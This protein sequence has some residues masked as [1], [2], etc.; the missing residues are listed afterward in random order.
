[1]KLI[2]LSCALLV[3]I[4][5]SACVTGT[6]EITLEVPATASGANRSGQIYIASIDDEREFQHKP[7]IP[8]TPSVSGNLE[9]KTPAELNTYV[10]R[11]RNGYGA[12]MGSVALKDG[13]TVQAETRKVLVA[14]LEARGYEVVESADNAQSVSVDIDKF[15]AW[16]VPGFIS[17]GFES[18]VELELE[19]DG[20]TA[21]AYGNG[22]NEGQ[23]A[24]N[25][26]WALTYKRAY[27]KLLDSL[28][29]ALEDIGL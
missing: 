3:L 24:S 2:K 7:R 15:W 29:S 12:A 14:S 28:D 25:A 4:S 27:G 11:Q 22:N 8:E 23:T 5:T 6:R 17:T 18:E 13:S 19:S 20:K 26:N 10:G 21:V 1:M 16:M 9:K